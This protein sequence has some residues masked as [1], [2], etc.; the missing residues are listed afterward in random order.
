MPVF[1][2]ILARP[3]LQKIYTGLDFEK[4]AFVARVSACWAEIR[5]GLF[6]QRFFAAGR[7]LCTAQ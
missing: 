5:L 7:G 3:F 2:R 4:H 1:W 6:P